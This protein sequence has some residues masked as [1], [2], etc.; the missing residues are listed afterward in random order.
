[1]TSPAVLLTGSYVDLCTGTLGHIVRDLSPELIK[2]GEFGVSFVIR[3]RPRP[4]PGDDNIL[5][6]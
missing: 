6:M 3:R 2:F 4:F 1:M 5:C